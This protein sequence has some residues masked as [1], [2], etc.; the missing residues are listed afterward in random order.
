MMQKFSHVTVLYQQYAHE[1]EIL[2]YCII[3]C[4]F[5]SLQILLIERRSSIF[6]SGIL[7]IHNNLKVKMVHHPGGRGN[8]YG[9][10]VMR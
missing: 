9:E 7:D 5:Y 4:I 1:V 10:T 6:Y 3:N 2:C 8:V